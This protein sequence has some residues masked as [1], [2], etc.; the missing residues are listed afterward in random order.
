MDGF[1]PGRTPALAWNFELLR[2]P[3]EVRGLTTSY[4]RSYCDAGC[5]IAAIGGEIRRCGSG[6]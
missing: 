5:V 4:M 3:R 6:F 1:L 2:R